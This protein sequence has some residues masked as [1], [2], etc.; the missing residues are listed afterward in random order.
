MTKE[1]V[2]L[3]KEILD[4]YGSDFSAED[5]SSTKTSILR[6]NTQS[7]ET[8]GSLVGILQNIS[9]YDLPLDYVK[10][11]EAT[12]KS[13]D[14][15]EAQRL[16]AEYMNPDKLIYVVV[17]DGKTQLKRLDNIGLGKPV[18][19]NKDDESLVIKK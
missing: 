9:T 5:M 17:G 2:E 3:F 4:N 15:A 1:S 11:E 8:L 18:L 7:Y 10:K 12:L 13:M 19:V 14:V 16:I 6:S